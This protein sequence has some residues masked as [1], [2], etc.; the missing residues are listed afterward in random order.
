MN[1]PSA[2]DRPWSLGLKGRAMMRVNG[3]GR[4]GRDAPFQAWPAAALSRMGPE[5]A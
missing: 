2:F 1:P 4:N 5:R 3:L